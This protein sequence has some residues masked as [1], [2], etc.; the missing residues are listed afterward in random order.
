MHKILP[1]PRQIALSPQDC[2]GIIEIVRE[3]FRMSRRKSP[4]LRPRLDR[5]KSG[6]ASGYRRKAI[7]AHPNGTL[8]S[9]YAW[10]FRADRFPQDPSAEGRW[11]QGLSSHAAR[12]ERCLPQEIVASHD[13]NENRHLFLRS[14]RAAR[15]RFREKPSRRTAACLPKETKPGPPMDCCVSP[16]GRDGRT[17]GPPG[18]RLFSYRESGRLPE[19]S[20]S[21]LPGTRTD[22]SRNLCS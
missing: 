18:P 3:K 20:G 22:F 21:A 1:R 2:R 9:G 17:G 4:W 6:D 14:L 19:A 15:A 16:W 12:D 5:P 11:L 10:H 8:W 13:P 7:A